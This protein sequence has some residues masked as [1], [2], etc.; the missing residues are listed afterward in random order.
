VIYCNVSLLERYSNYI[1]S[2]DPELIRTEHCCRSV[3]WCM[4]FSPPKLLSSFWCSYCSPESRSIYSPISAQLIRNSLFGSL[5]IVLGTISYDLVR[6][7]NGL[8]VLLFVFRFRKSIVSIKNWVAFYRRAQEV[9][10]FLPIFV[11]MPWSICCAYGSEVTLMWEGLY[12]WV[13]NQI[14]YN[15]LGRCF[16]GTSGPNLFSSGNEC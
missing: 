2:C 9:K 3:V 10:I 8:L 14:T 4:D 13:R 12:V 5:A 11:L 15:S 1:C 16:D 7:Y 6:S